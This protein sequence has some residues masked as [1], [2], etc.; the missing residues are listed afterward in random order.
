MVSPENHLRVTLFIKE[1]GTEN[2]NLTYAMDRIS[3][4]SC[5]KDEG[6][7]MWFGHRAA[8]FF[9]GHLVQPSA[10]AGNLLLQLSCLMIFYCLIMNF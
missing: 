7:V 5:K 9:K 6:N 2:Y 4:S 3:E 8:T 10:R 1:E